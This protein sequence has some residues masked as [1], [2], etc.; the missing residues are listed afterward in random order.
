MTIMTVEREE[1]ERLE[2]HLAEARAALKAADA[3]INP[4]DR[5]GISLHVWNERLRDAT[6][7]IR[8]ALSP[9]PDAVRGAGSTDPTQEALRRIDEMLY[10]TKP[11][12]KEQ[13]GGDPA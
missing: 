12:A 4:P 2:R 6:K 11:A 8:Q 9:E 13:D 3:A 7:I 1:Y 10:V 5:S